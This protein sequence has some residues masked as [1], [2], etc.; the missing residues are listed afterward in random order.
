MCFFLFATTAL[1]DDLV[2]LPVVSC[3]KIEDLLAK[4]DYEGALHL[5][6]VMDG[7]DVDEKVEVGISSLIN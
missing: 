3:V 4:K 1:L 7:G 6:E 2:R 5:C